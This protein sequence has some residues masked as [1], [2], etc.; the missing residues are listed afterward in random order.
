MGTCLII[1][2][3]SESVLAGVKRALLESGRCP[4][5]AIHSATNRGTSNN[6]HSFSHSSAGQT[7]LAGNVWAGPR[8]LCGR[9]GGSLPVPSGGSRPPVAGDCITPASAAAF[10]WLLWVSPISPN[11]SLNQNI[12]HWTWGPWGNLG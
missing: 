3:I 11:L 2:R 5:A 7:L 10:T 9:W 6:R 8:S 12:C 4:T 1:T